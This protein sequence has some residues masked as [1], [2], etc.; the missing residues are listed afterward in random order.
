MLDFVAGQLGVS[1][2]E[3]DRYAV[4]G[5]TRYRHSADLQRLLGYRPC[6]GRAR[7]DLIDW[8]F[9]IAGSAK[10][11]VDLATVCIR[12]MRR[13]KIIVLATTTVERLCASAMTTTESQTL[14]T[15]AR[16]LDERVRARLVMLLTDAEGGRTSQFVWLRRYEVGKNTADMHR[17]L[18]RLDLL[19]RLGLKVEVIND[20][21]R[22]QIDRPSWRR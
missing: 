2:D 13:R 12:E 5:T 14:S 11:N 6:S 15:I 21:P 3:A 7:D 4:T 10:A 20:L 16:R 22:R 18:D 8:L 17:L 19:N 9:E 1:A